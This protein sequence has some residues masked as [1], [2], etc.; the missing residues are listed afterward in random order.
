MDILKFALVLSAG[1]GTT[2]IAGQLFPGNTGQRAAQVVVA[3]AESE[4]APQEQQPAAP[5][6]EASADERPSL[7][8]P[9]PEEIEAE[10]ARIDEAL[11]D[12]EVLEEFTPSEPLSADLSV[13]LP[14]D[15]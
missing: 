11:A 14:S 13:D 3:Q 12:E 6:T 1:L 5:D 7:E 9:M 2:W 10:L 4:P 15:I 8:E